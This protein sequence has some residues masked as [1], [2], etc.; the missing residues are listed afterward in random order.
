MEYNVFQIEEGT[1]Q[2]NLKDEAEG[3]EE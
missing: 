2:E 3:E 1:I